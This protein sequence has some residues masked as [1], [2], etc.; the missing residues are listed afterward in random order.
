MKRSYFFVN[1]NS[2]STNLTTNPKKIKQNRKCTK[3]E[4]NIAFPQQYE[5]DIS[6]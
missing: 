2:Q 5:I 4:Q 6:F 1:P 3:E